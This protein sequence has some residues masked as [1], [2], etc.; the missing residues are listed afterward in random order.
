[1][2]GK[3][4]KFLVIRVPSHIKDKLISSAKDRNISLSKV[5]REILSKEICD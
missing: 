4:D 2:N 5:V 1:M 3:K